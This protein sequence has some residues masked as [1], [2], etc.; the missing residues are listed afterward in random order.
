MS[1]YLINYKE[2]YY[3]TT[4]DKKDDNPLYTNIIGLILKTLDS[5]QYI[6]NKKKYYESNNFLM[7]AGNILPVNVHTSISHSKKKHTLSIT[8]KL[9]SNTIVDQQTTIRTHIINYKSKK[10]INK[11][12]IL[13]KI[14]NDPNKLTQYIYISNQN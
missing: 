7:H 10:N 3:S 12:L 1:K 9:T 6:I 4:Y 13:N 2:I 5:Y 8:I 14:L 11:F